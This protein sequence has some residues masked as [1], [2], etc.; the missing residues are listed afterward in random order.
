MISMKR[1]GVIGGTGL[2]DILVDDAIRSDSILAETPWGSVPLQCVTLAESEIIFVQR[3]HGAG[4][5]PPHKIEHRANIRAL[6]D[7]G[8]EAILA[9]CSVGAIAAEF[10]PGSMTY[11]E[12]YLDLTGVS[13][14]F[15][16]DD[17]LFTSM[18][19]PFSLHLNEILA[20]ELNSNKGL[21][22]F[23][24]Q[25]PQFETVAEIDAIER[26]GGDAVGMTMPR[27]A[28]LAAELDLPYAAVLISSNWAAGRTPGDPSAILD[29]HAVSATAGERLEKVMD[30]IRAILSQG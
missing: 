8:V 30:C 16:D 19:E 14:T 29:H 23:L 11:A 25:G 3:H 2:E 5:T 18:T 15:N 4:C 22:Y 1:L 13:S 12:Q 6:A 10:T 28:K 17:A 26:L 24:T 7:A 27:E 20:K 9:I 21:T